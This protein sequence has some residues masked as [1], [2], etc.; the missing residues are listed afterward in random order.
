MGATKRPGRWSMVR[1]GHHVHDVTGLHLV[2]AVDDD[3][4]TYWSV[5]SA[6]P[7]HGGVPEGRR[8]VT[9]ADAKRYA[10]R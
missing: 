6:A 1:S 3:D 7:E 2:R 8:Q 9:L 4:E 10:L 5:W